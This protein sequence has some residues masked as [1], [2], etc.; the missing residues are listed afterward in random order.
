MATNNSVNSP[1]SGTTGSGNFVGA[2]SPIVTGLTSDQ[3][4]WSDTTKG[5]VGTTTNNDADSGYVGEY[6]SSQVSSGSPVSLTSGATSNVT[7]ITLT[8][9][10]WDVFYNTVYF[11]ASTTTLTRVYSGLSST[12]ATQPG[13]ND[14][15][16][17]IQ[18]IGITGDGANV[19]YNT[20]G[21]TRVSV[22]SSTTYYAVVQGTF[23]VSTCTAFGWLWARRVR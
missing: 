5:I 17:T 14:K 15:S 2:T 21:S 3:I 18:T 1:L 13:I 12:S 23:A 6:L 20:N 8:A 11:P 22:A 7:S 10:D 4:T 16:T 9:G 19:F